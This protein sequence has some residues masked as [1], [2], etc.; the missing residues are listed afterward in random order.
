LERYQWPGNVREL[1]NCARYLS[2]LTAGDMAQISDLPQ[3]IRLAA[4][5]ESQK[6]VNAPQTNGTHSTPNAPQGPAVRYDLS[7]KKAKRL[8]LEVFEYAYINRLLE[9][10]DGNI[11]HAARAAGIDRK[12]IQRLMKR[13]EMSLPQQKEEERSPETQE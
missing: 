9:K 1:F 7:Y 3:R 8:W 12:S 11:S 13:N 6:P 10:H 4:G 5:A 2:G